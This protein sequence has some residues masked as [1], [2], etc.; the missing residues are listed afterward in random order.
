MPRGK[1]KSTSAAPAE[2]SSEPKSVISETEKEAI[3]VVSSS[4]PPSPMMTDVE[5]DSTTVLR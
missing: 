4:P 2:I 1:S 3:N 5:M